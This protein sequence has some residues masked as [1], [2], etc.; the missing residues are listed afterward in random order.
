[1]GGSFLF[2]TLTDALKNR[3]RLGVF[4]YRQP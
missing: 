2:I 3:Q 4:K 1:M